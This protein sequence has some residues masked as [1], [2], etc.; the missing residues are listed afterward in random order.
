MSKFA[1]ALEMKPQALQSY[2]GGGSKPGNKMQGKLRDLG[3][4]IDWLMTGK[5]SNESEIGDIIPLMN[6]PVYS[7]VNAGS[8]KWVVS[9][10]IIDYIAIPRSSDNT[11]FGLVVKGDSMYDEIK[12]GDTIILSGKADI[13]NGDLCVVEW[14]DGDKH[15][16][17]VAFDKNNIVLTSKNNLWRNYFSDSPNL[18]SLSRKIVL[19][20]CASRF[21]SS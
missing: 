5:I 12:D 16:R 17:R 18:K 20:I 19:W 6:V 8:K 1:A 3:C 21:E 2:L 4:D 7:H 10:E 9:D 14:I 15:L 11:L 13:K